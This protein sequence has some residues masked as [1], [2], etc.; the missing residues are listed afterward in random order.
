MKEKKQRKKIEYSK[1]LQKFIFL[2][3]F[4]EKKFEIFIFQILTIHNIAFFLKEISFYA[5][6]LSNIS[7]ASLINF[8]YNE[9]DQNIV[10][11]QY[12]I[13]LCVIV[14]FF[15]E[16]QPMAS[17]PDDSFLSSDQDTN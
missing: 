5:C 12:Y 8:V 14:F 15:R 11:R 9:N 3:S 17:V 13:H 10:Y 7:Y 2:F 16:F 4:F 6:F 1:P